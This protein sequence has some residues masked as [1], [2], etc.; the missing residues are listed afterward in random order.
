MGAGGESPGIGQEKGGISYQKLARFHPEY[1]DDQERVTQ[2]AKF[3]RDEESGP[4][5]EDIVHE[6]ARK[7]RI[8][9][10]QPSYLESQRQLVAQSGGGAE[11]SARKPPNVPGLNFQ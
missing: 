10:R 4:E 2:T 1:C 11:A 3:F 7:E 9:E 8:R 6:M 5:L